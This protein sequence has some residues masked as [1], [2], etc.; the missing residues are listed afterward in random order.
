[1]VF[2]ASLLPQAFTDKGIHPRL[3]ALGRAVTALEGD[4]A[5]IFYNPASIGSSHAPKVFAGYTDMYPTIAD[6]DLSVMN[7]AGTFGVEGY[8]TFGVG[9]TQF[10]PNFWT[11]RTIVLAGASDAFLDHLS[12]GASLKVLM[13]SSASPQGEYAV[14]EPGISYS[15]ISFDL[16]MVY[17]MPEIL[18]QNDL[19]V[20]LSLQDVT[21]PSVASNGS[22]DAALPMG[23]TLGGAFTSRKHHYA[24]YGAAT[25]KDSDLK[26]AAGYEITA[27]KTELA[28]ASGE[29]IVRFGGARVTGA[30][31]QGEYNGGFGLVVENVRIDY[32]YSYQAFLRN[33]GG[34]S[35]VAVS[36]D[37]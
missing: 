2:P 12:V 19:S 4:P 24:M 13:W 33:V 14:P 3:T 8:G 30:E 18:D 20:G 27:L 16:G 31:T 6:D 5:L 17:Q 7:A 11:E 32:S 25:F 36:Y 10:S 37:F 26:L 28:G 1:M 34:I 35:S 22:A 23:I 15:G 21:S 29:F 9:I